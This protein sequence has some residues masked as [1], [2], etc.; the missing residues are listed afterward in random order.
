VGGSRTGSRFSSAAGL[1]KVPSKDTGFT[2]QWSRAV[3]SK[4]FV[5]VGADS[6]WVDGDSLEAAFN[7]IPAATAGTFINLT[8]ISGGSQQ[9]FGVFVQDLITL[10]PRLQISLSARLDH[11]RNYDGHNLETNLITGPTAN[12]KPNLPEKKNTFGNPHVGA[13]YHVSDSVA[14]WGGLSWGFR[15]PTLNELYRSF[16]VGTVVTQA[17][18]NLGAERLFGGEAGVNIAPIRN[19]TWR[20]TW[21]LDNYKDP[22]S[23]VT[24]SVVGANITRQRKNLGKARIAGLQSDLEYR[25]KS[26]WRFSAGYLYDLA[27][28]KEY[29]AQNPS[30]PSLVGRFLA[31]VPRNRGSVHLS[32]ANPKYA[33]VA[34]GALFVGRQ[35]DDDQNLLRLPGYGVVDFS[36]NRTISRNV[37][38]FFG[39]QNLLDREFYVQR[40]PTTL[41]APRLVT[42]GFRISFVGR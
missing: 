14:V 27:R 18:E 7:A 28:V 10:I 26:Y 34:V 30:D 25:F 29:V 33:T 32:Y 13:L 1:Q 2:V 41:G 9:S 40:N 23:N 22:V 37:E 12:N 20:T 15:A 31:N 8:R 24:L 17:N 5:T 39:V 21:F 3:A 19:L 11:W 16:S 36:V 4:Q 42:G 35:Y 6:R 38:A